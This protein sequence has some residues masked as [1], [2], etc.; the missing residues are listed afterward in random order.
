MNQRYNELSIRGLNGWTNLFKPPLIHLFPQLIHKI[1][2][3]PILFT[4]SLI[5]PTRGNHLHNGMRCRKYSGKLLQDGLHS[6]GLVRGCATSVHPS[7]CTSCTHSYRNR[8]TSTRIYCTNT[9]TNIRG[10]FGRM[11]VHT[12][13]VA[14]K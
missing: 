3:T 1:S 2:H 13:I 11:T 4:H 14:V 12:Q 9:K 8:G 10:T 7:S 5:D 6:Q